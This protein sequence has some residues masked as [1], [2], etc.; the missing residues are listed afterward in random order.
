M[1]NRKPRRINAPLSYDIVECPEVEEEHRESKRQYAHTFHHKGTICVCK[2]FWRLPPKHRDAI[3]L[4]EIGHL[5][6]GPEGGE[7]DANRAVEEVLGARIEYVCSPYG[8]DLEV[9][10]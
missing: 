7:E 3:L 5:L 10:R 2:E 9:V 8:D 4:H 6:V 1:A